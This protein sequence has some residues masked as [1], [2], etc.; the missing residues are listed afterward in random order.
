MV[1]PVSPFSAPASSFW[2]HARMTTFDSQPQ[3]TLNNVVLRLMDGSTGR[4]YLRGTG[5]AGIL[6]ISKRT[7]AGVF[8]D[9]V[10]MTTPMVFTGNHINAIDLYVNYFSS[11]TVTLYVDGVVAAT[12]SGDV[13]TNSATTLN[14]VAA[15][16]LIG[17][18]LWTLEPRAAGVTQTFTPN[19]LANINELII[20]DGTFI[21]SV[22]NNNLSGWTTP[23]VYPTDVLPAQV[24]AV[25]GVVQTT[26]AR[27]VTSAQSFAYHVWTNGTDTGGGD[28][29]LTASFANYG[30]QIWSKNPVTLLPWETTEV[31]VA[32]FN[33][34]VM[35]RGASEQSV[36]KIVSYAVLVPICP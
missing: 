18:A 32:G 23:T 14:I 19:T 35:N 3:T 28:V 1:V 8:T 15:Q 12:Y 21:N 6:K 27:F 13:T 4:L 20:A 29:A 22:V 11:G 7:G 34:G 2:F 33:L 5:T 24:W 26:R 36:S 30:P 10:T 25:C 16:P 9:L 31:A 17:S